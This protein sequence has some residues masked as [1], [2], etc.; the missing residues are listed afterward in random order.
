MHANGSSFST[1]PMNLA[2]S[3]TVQ[4]P[5]GRFDYDG[6][7][8]GSPATDKWASPVVDGNELKFF[9][10][11]SGSQ[12]QQHQQQNNHSSTSASAFGHGHS[13]SFSG[14]LPG[15]DA[16]SPYLSGFDGSEFGSGGGM[17]GGGFGGSRAPGAGSS[18]AGGTG[19]TPPSAG[20]VAPGLPFHGL[21]FIRNYDP[22]GNASAGPSAFSSS[23]NDWSNWQSSFDSFGVDPETA[24]TL[25]GDFTTDGQWGSS[26]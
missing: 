14:Q 7:G 20:F 23:D 12:Q 4:I 21:D 8:L 15:L 2:Q 1:G 5:G 18:A 16:T 24:F 9:P 10:S 25:G 3:P 6:F 19:T 17:G 11:G 26:G 13:R 22:A